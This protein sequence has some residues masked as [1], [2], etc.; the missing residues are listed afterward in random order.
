M[1]TCAELFS[2]FNADEGRINLCLAP[3][4]SLL[5]FVD[6]SAI[7]ISTLNF[8]VY[9]SC[10]AEPICEQPPEPSLIDFYE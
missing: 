10:W 6:G 8:I 4:V 1:R 7:Y 9:E 5:L 3:D 2:R